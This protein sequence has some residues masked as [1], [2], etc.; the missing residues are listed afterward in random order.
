MN[1][2]SLAPEPALLAIM[3]IIGQAFGEKKKKTFNLLKLSNQSAYT[4]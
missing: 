3:H 4:S 2:D 1:G